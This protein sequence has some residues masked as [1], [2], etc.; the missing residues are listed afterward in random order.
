MSK[1]LKETPNPALTSNEVFPWFQPVVDVATGR[2]VGYEA[3]ARQYNDEGEVVSAAHLLRADNDLSPAQ[4]LELDRSLRVRA[5]KMFAEKG[6]EGQVLALNL[7]PEWID[8]LESFEQLPTLDMIRE[9]GVKPEQVLLE[10]TEINGDID[11]IRELA[12]LYRNAGV[13]VAYDDFGAGFQQLDRLMAFTPDVIKLDI[14]MFSAGEI[15]HQKRALM[16]M[17]GDLGARMGCKVVF[18]G[19]ETED[20]FFLALHCNASHIQGFLFSPAQA[21]MVARDTYK[22]QVKGLL[23]SHLD[24]AI[25]ETAR[26]QFH[27]ERLKS[28]LMALRELLLAGGDSHLD[29]FRPDPDILRFYV[30]DR[31]GN[32]ISANWSFRDEQWCA[33]ETVIGA[34]WSWRPYFYQLVGSE[35]YNTRVM[36]STSYS[37][38]ATGRVCHTLS[39]ALDERRVLLVDVV[40]RAQSPR[41][42]S[43][44]IACQ[45][46]RMPSLS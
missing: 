27:H 15:T 5:L 3:L 33:D 7:S 38:I 35:D 41:P 34:N 30:C 39:L 32:Q 46:D 18:E 22:T 21:E 45:S 1:I 10:I 13:R 20:E 9:A 26:R 25:D 4:R 28:E 29:S 31:Q 40:D 12:T 14:R 6:E 24:L 17:V 23:E 42:M 37:D 16:Q 43:A 44:L 19:V 36:S 8:S 11:R 2:V